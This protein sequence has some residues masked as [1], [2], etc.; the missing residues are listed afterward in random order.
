MTARD[1][2]VRGLLAGLLAGIATFVVAFTVGEPSVQSAVELEGAHA[3]SA[4]AHPGAP[5]HDE[6]PLVSR[7]TQRTWGLA[8]A[9]LT[10]GV[11][12]GG[13]VGLVAAATM[14]RLGRPRPLPPAASTAL[15]ALVGWL[16]VALVP[17]LKY[18]ANPPSVGD[19]GTIGRRTALFFT[20]LLVSVLTAAAATA[21]AS[22]L[23]ARHGA[24]TAVLAGVAAYLL[25]VGTTGAL[26]PSVD[27]VG[28]FPASTLW[29]FRRASLLTSATT[30]AVLGVVLTG[31]V[32]G[33]HRRD[34]ETRSRRE[35]AASL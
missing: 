1:L 13:L 2:L 6:A 23:R 20:F 32:G 4:T 5:A 29:Y 15:V 27:E 7:H 17:F 12:L 28:D 14:G 3:A 21:L 8:T 25:V 30:W 9:S 10:V 31:L 19:P 35:L 34:A 11:A 22:R 26:L 24:Y 16:A 33:L 18:P